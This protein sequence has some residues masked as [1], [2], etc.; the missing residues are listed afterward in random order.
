TETLVDRSKNLGP[1]KRFLDT[2]N[3]KSS[4]QTSQSSAPSDA[5]EARPVDQATESKLGGETSEQTDQDV[6]KEVDFEPFDE[7]LL[8]ID[9]DSL[10]LNRETGESIEVTEPLG[11]AERF[12]IETNSA[13]NEDSGFSTPLAQKAVEPAFTLTSDASALGV[14][15]HQE[16]VA[17]AVAADRFAEETIFFEEALAIDELLAD[18]AADGLDSAADVLLR[19]AE[20]SLRQE[21]RTIQLELSPAELGT[22][23]IQVLQ[24][25]HSI[26]TQIVASEAVASELLNAHREQLTAALQSLGFETSDVEISHQPSQDAFDDLSNSAD[27]ADRDSQRREVFS[28]RRSAPYLSPTQPGSQ[29]SA[30]DSAG[31]LN[32]IA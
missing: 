12:R 14:S 24:T 10:R 32:L 25:E 18:S 23:R 15:I 8:D 2:A 4:Q 30:D 9:A 11:N 29:T 16:L 3:S 26:E 28:Q 7:S 17:D 13:L 31:G 21:G 6:G 5:A 27:Q 19:A 20:T 22:L 1:T